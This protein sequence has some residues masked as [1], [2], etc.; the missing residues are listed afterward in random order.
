MALQITPALEQRLE[1]LAAATHRSAD[2]LAQEGLDA[3]IAR[4]ENVLAI[5]ERG[6]ADLAAG[7]TLGPEEVFARIDEMLNQR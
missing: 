2:D 4:E 6:R 7:R 5:L 3:F 1:H